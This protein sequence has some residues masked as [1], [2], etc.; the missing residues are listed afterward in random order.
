[1]TQFSIKDLADFSGIKPHTI[2]IWEQRFNFLKPNR[3]E[4]ARRVYNPE[5]LNL[6]LEVMLLNQNGYKISKIAGMSMEDK[7][8]L[9]D[10]MDAS[11]QKLRTIN[12]LIIAMAEMDKE[13][14]EMILDVSIKYWG[15]DATIQEVLLPF[16][17][18]T[19]LL[20]DPENK[21]YVENIAVIEQSVRQK[22]YLG[23]EHIKVPAAQGKTVLLLHTPEDRQHLNL[24]FL[25]YMLKQRGFKTLHISN[26][27]S[28]DH[29]KTIIEFKRPD[30]L[31]VH[32]SLKEKRGNLT[33]FIQRIGDQFTT[34]QFISIGNTLS[35]K[36]IESRYKYAAAIQAA[37]DLIV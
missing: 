30:Y 17:N 9:I 36:G 35:V 19:G 22:L 18:K 11:Q 33:R 37:N 16:S 12:E 1:M 31:V 15:L 20:Q 26:H 3:T 32:P 21:Y 5:E 29:I 8:Q 2:R 14:F 10:K 23:I 13:K 7:L 25:Q 24:L 6:F 27:L 34:V 28:F 4:T